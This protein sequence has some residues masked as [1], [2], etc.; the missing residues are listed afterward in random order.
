MAEKREAVNLRW[1]VAGLVMSLL[2][3]LF[4]D[5]NLTA[6]FADDEIPDDEVNNLLYGAMMAA[7]TRR[8]ITEDPRWQELVKLYRYDWVTAAEVLFNKIPTGSRRKLSNQFSRPAAG[9]RFP[10]AMVRV[11][12]T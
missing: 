11:S 10:P 2:T 7:I 8:S 4:N 3:V 6:Q 5:I 1:M 12:P 9:R